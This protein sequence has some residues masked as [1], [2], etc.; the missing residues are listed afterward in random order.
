MS[1]IF[2]DTPYPL[3]KEGLWA[4]VRVPVPKGRPALFLDRDGVVVEDSHYLNRPEDVSLMA[5][6]AD[7]IAHAN[8]MDIPVIIVTNQAGIAYGYFGWD[9]FA[10]VQE[11][12]LGEIQ[13][14][15]GGIVDA[16]FACPFHAKGKPPYQ[17]PDPPC[18]KPNPGMIVEAARMMDIDLGRSW[19]VG[20]KDIDMRAGLNAGLAG[21]VH[22][23][24]GH[25]KDTGEREK[26]LA[27][28]T[29]EFQ[30]FGADDIQGAEG[31]IPFLKN[32]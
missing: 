25:G 22:V 6:A 7:V 14:A 16:V 28:A 26:A 8:T 24:S 18:R 30:V 17:H 21:G 12:I 23:A 20:D 32:S 2:Q 1:D 11:K 3:T 27:V 19:I 29:G 10:L 13:K 31:L 15:T 9:S 5:G 4:E